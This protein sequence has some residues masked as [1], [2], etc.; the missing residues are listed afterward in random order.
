MTQG[1]SVALT[2]REGGATLFLGPDGPVTAAAF[3][4]RAVAFA[5]AL[6]PGTHAINLCSGRLAFTLAFAAAALRGQV[7]LLCADASPAH[8]RR[9]ADRFGDAFVITDRADC[10][11]PLRTFMLPDLST[12]LA[13]AEAPRIPSEQLAALVFTSGSSGEPVA[14]P[15]RWGQLAARSR[16]AGQQFA[17]RGASVVATVP[18]QHMYGFETSVLLP[19]HAP[20]AVW[21]GDSFFPADIVSALRACPG[22]RVLI[23]TPLH[24]RTLLDARAAV[25]PGTKVIS[26]T[27]PLPVP[28]AAEAEKRWGGHVHEIFGATEVGSIA[29]RRTVT[30]DAWRTYPGVEVGTAT[31]RA[32]GAEETELSDFVEIV[33]GGFRLIGRRSDL[34]KVGGRR[35]SLAGLTEALLRIPG[36]QDAAIA[37][38]TPDEDRLVAFV[39]APG[40]TADTLLAVLRGSVDPVFLPRP[41]VVVASLPRNAVGK[42]T[43]A[44]L[45]SLREAAAL[46]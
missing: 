11:A 43:A 34:V 6:P 42:L 20:A 4:G 32:P 10:P 17:F 21:C 46:A 24:L 29:S 41:L 8:L 27:A 37:P 5:A 35:A 13:V 1:T 23:T 2:D 9:L 31:V 44:G 3:T 25:P 36:V 16:A 19:L 30:G 26:A 38:P 15:K 22:P 14:H 18:P 7:S 28:L 12:A 33:P 45:R 39:V 40:Q